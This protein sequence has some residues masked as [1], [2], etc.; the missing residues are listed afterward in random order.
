M[1]TVLITGAGRGIGL[2]LA[3]QYL[4]AGSEVIA[5]QRSASEVLSSL[6]GSERLTVLLASLTDDQQMHNALEQIGD[7]PLDVVINNA[8]AMDDNGFGAFD[9]ARWHEVFDINVFTP[10]AVAERLVE[11]V[12]AAG[13]GRIVTISSIL[14]SIEKNSDGGMYGYR[15]SKAAVDAI[16]RTM[17]IDL[18]GR[19]ILC[20][21]LHPGWVKTDMGSQR[22]PLTPAESVSGLIK[23]IAGLDA[24]SAGKLLDWR[25]R[26]L[27]W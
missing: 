8:G 13:N 3:R 12:A 21:A 9:R 5:L 22:A 1:T 20:A 18:A 6:P 15:A 24:S 27:P 17:A 23:V 16:M 10:M 4:A 7:R 19:G 2:E 11:N 14:G 26:T 25:G